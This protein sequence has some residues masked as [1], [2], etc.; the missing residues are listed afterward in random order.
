MHGRDLAKGTLNQIANAS[1][2]DRAEFLK[3]LRENQDWAV[4]CPS[5]TSSK[6]IPYPRRHRTDLGLNDARRGGYA[7]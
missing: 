2:L 4:T 7:R 5:P 1:G 6:L 3:L